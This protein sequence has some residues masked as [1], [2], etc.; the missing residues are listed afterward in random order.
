MKPFGTL[1]TTS[2]TR[3]GADLDENRHKNKAISGI[4]EASPIAQPR[5]QSHSKS[6]WDGLSCI[7]ITLVKLG[8]RVPGSME[9]CLI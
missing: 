5:I 7:S 3:S 6:G 1:S 8:F 2:L 4:W 9:L